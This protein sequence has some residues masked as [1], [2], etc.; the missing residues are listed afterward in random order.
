[1]PDSN[2]CYTCLRLP[3]VAVSHLGYSAVRDRIVKVFQSAVRAL[4]K[5]DAVTL[6]SHD[7]R[8]SSSANEHESKGTATLDQTASHQLGSTEEGKKQEERIGAV[9]VP[10][11]VPLLEKC[12]LQIDKEVFDRWCVIG[13]TEALPSDTDIASFLI[14]Q[15]EKVRSGGQ[16]A[17]SCVTCNTP[18]T[19]FCARCMQPSCQVGRQTSPNKTDVNNHTSLKEHRRKFKVKSAAQVTSKDLTNNEGVLE[20]NTQTDLPDH[21]EET[22]HKPSLERPESGAEDKDDSG[23]ETHIP[24][25][26]AFGSSQNKQPKPKS[27]SAKKSR[28]RKQKSAE[29]KS[30]DEEKRRHKC[31]LCPAAFFRRS[32]LFAHLVRHGIETP[33]KCRQCPASFKKYAELQAHDRDVH[34]GKN[35]VCKLCGTAFKHGYKLTEHMR[36]HSGEKPYVCDICGVGYITAA[37]RNI[38]RRIHTGEK[39]YMCSTCGKTFARSGC[40]AVHKRTHQVDKPHICTECGRA[41]KHQSHLKEHMVIHSGLKPYQCELCGKAMAHRSTLKYHMRTH[42]GQKP[43]TCPVCGK[44]FGTCSNMWQHRRTHKTS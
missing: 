32:N 1:M 10:P 41:F 14:E 29:E 8:E 39:P 7:N 23:D 38:H 33:H 35:Y 37:D 18:L 34:L 24:A 31:D 11:L 27:A 15:Y 25:K 36:R 43:Y 2:V 16:Q 22:E 44:A 30:Q 40:L 20:V 12:S 4:F 9:K 6:A 21:G 19:L 42:T 17:A 28:K 26:S 5:M 13:I 3:D